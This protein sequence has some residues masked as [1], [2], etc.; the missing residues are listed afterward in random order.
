MAIPKNSIAISTTLTKASGVTVTFDDLVAGS[1]VFIDANC[2]VYAA[3]ADPQYGPACQRLLQRIENKEITG[4]TAAHVLAEM[5]HRLMTIEAASR[6]TPNQ[7]K[8]RLW[9]SLTRSLS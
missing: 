6:R 7:P 9:R 4:F 3:T 2:L 5:A 8:R 1:A